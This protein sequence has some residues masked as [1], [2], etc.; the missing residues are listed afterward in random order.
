MNKDFRCMQV[1]EQDK[2]E[3][4]KITERQGYGKRQMSN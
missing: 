4:T 2:R 1:I 3:K